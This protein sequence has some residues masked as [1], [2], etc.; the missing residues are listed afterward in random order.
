MAKIPVRPIRTPQ[1]ASDFTKN[2][3]IREIQVKLRGKDLTED[4][5]RHDHFFL[6]AL[7]EGKGTHHIDFT[8]YSVTDRAV[9]LLRPGQVHQLTLKAHSTGYLIK[10]KPGFHHAAD[11]SFNQ[12][13]R[14][15]SRTNHYQPDAAQFKKLLPLLA[16]LQQE[17]TDKQEGYEEVIQST[18]GILLIALQRQNPRKESESSDA[19]ALERFED[20]M[21]LL[22]T[23]IAVYKQVSQ[24]ADM[25]NLSP[26]QLN[27][28]TKSMVGKTCSDLINEQIILEAKRQILA[29]ADQISHIAHDL[30]YDDVSYFIRFFKKHT[31]HSPEV[32]RQKFK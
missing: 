23:R 15:V 12:L 10:F 21:G 24:Y 5:H 26:Y 28:I 1:R 7:N 19:Y 3:T 18:L 32:F 30:G 2:F 25:L 16:L 27:A 31:G 13:V 8:P 6:L 29:T 9:F 14:H 17:Y 20:L 4:L 11:K 22:E